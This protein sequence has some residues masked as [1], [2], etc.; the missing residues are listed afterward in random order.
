M[1]IVT[2]ASQP[3]QHGL[4]KSIVL[5]CFLALFA[6]FIIQ[7]FRSWYR[8][9]H[10]PGPFWASVTSLWM[11]RKA[12]TGK[13]HE[14]LRDVAEKYGSFKFL[15]PPSGFLLLGRLRS[16]WDKPELTLTQ[17]HSPV[18]APTKYCQ[19]TPMLSV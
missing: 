6:F 14:H 18:S 5:P 12:L 3:A 2:A 11:L 13:L 1:V 7:Q 10:I 4:L 17:A 8:L 19:R 9:R 16:P 15:S